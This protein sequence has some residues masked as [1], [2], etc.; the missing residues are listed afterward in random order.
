MC[1]V[2]R[3][4]AV[5]TGKKVGHSRIPSLW[6]WRVSS[7]NLPARPRICLFVYLSYKKPV[8]LSVCMFLYLLDHSSVF[9][10]DDLSVCLSVCVSLS[11]Y[12]TTALCLL[13][14]IPPYAFGL[15]S[16]STTMINPTELNSIL[17][18]SGWVGLEWVRLV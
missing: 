8:C 4:L 9:L 15:L 1:T 2:G 17:L 3:S 7:A 11:T 5:Q 13:T 14:Q 6:G 16:V 18:R 10:P 12:L